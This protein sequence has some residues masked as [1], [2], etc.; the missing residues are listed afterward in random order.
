MSLVK[1]TALYQAIVLTS[2]HCMPTDANRVQ[3][4]TLR[5]F[6]SV[7]M[8]HSFTFFWMMRDVHLAVRLVAERLFRMP[9]ASS[10]VQ[11]ALHAAGSCYVVGS[12]ASSSSLFARCQSRMSHVTCTEI[13]ASLLLEVLS[14]FKWCSG[15]IL[16]TLHVDYPLQSPK[17]P[18]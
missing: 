3:N 9:H 10:W 4:F 16:G 17:Q 6:W 18:K 12:L 5:D 2:H 11:G 14:G 1:G 15:E 8:T 7:L 13:L